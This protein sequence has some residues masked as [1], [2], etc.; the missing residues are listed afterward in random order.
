MSKRLHTSDLVSHIQTQNRLTAAEARRQLDNVL[1]AIQTV[2][3][4]GTVLALR[5]FGIFENKIR[6]A[7][8]ARNPQTG[9]EIQVPEKATLR[10]RAAKK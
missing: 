1:S 3:T 4:P 10:F 6:P 7:R 5:S 9:A 8:T 2:T